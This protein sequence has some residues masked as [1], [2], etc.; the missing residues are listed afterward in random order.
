MSDVLIG[1]FNPPSM[2]GVKAMGAISGHDP[3]A[4]HGSGD[5]MHPPVETTVTA[6]AESVRMLQSLTF[7][8]V[9]RV[10]V[11][12]GNGHVKREMVCRV[13]DCADGVMFT[14]CNDQPNAG[15]IIIQESISEGCAHE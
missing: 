5:G 4:Y 13:E 6:D 1:R 8:R 15:T 11:T 9:Y 2:D 14:P 12:D 7:P 10:V 3:F